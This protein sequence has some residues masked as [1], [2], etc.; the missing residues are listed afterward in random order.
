MAGQR[1][2]DRYAELPE[3]TR[4]FLEELRPAEIVLLN[5]AINFMRSAETMGRFFRWTA[6]LVV[7]FFV[8]AV[9]LRESIDKFMGWFA[10]G[11]RP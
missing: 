10:G 6:I 4:A 11:P 9:A 7:S 8:G 2:V 5:K 1:E 3:K